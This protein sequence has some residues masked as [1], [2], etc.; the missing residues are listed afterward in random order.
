MIRR[1]LGLCSRDHGHSAMYEKLDSALTDFG[2]RQ[3]SWESL[4]HESE[5]QGVAPLL[6]KHLEYIGFTLPD[7]NHRILRSLAQRC[8]LSN[9][10]RNSTISEVL[11]IFRVE[12]IVTLL[13]KGIALANSIYSTP[14]LRPMRDIDLLVRGD[15]LGK[16]RKTLLEQGFRQETDHNIPEDYYHLPPLVKNIDGLP[17]TVE[18]HRSLLP[19]DGNYPEWPLE[20]LYE[21]SRP[22]SIEA[23]EAATLGP[24]QNLVYLYLHGLRAPLSYEPF[25]FVHIAD[26]VCLVERYFGEIN[27]YEAQGMFPQLGSILS[28]LHFVTPWPDQIISGLAL[29]ISKTPTRIGE[30]Y[31]GWPLVRL[32]DTP[33]PRWPLLV[34]DTIW[35]PQWWTQIHYGRIDRTGYFKVR[36]FE[37]PRT[38]WRWLKGNFRKRNTMVD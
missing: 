19:L 1:I 18:L 3:L 34:K 12:R 7:G 4:V 6:Y 23:T 31:A 9:Q 21:A 22:L 20:T 33:A 8:R 28:R 32:K 37:H 36:L 5:A 30:P 17:V 29:D 10:I 11:N 16:A 13:V 15:D 25:R 2:S 14:D 38:V 27:W 24:E 35:P 26:I